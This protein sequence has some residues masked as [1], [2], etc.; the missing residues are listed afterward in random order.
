MG[1]RILAVVFA[2]LALNAWAQVVL[3]LVG[4]SGDPG[5]LTALQALVGALAALA[6]WGSW[7]GA[8]WAAGAAVIHGLVTAGMIVALGPILGLDADERGGLLVGAAV[9]LGFGL[10][11]AWYL[12]R[13]GARVRAPSA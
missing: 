11:A 4:R 3:V 12:R 8:R 2:L 9:V 7:T 6:A 5:L 10:F 1:R 13:A